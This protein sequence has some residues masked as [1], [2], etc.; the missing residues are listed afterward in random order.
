MTEVIDFQKR[1]LALLQQCI[2][3]YLPEL[4]DKQ[5]LDVY[6]DILINISKLF[7]FNTYQFR[8]YSTFCKFTSFW[9]RK[10]LNFKL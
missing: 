9:Y 3:K 4:K 7:L 8:K 10:L 6:K 1:F 5:E 2:T